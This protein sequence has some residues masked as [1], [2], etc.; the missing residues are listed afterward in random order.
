[1]VGWFNSHVCQIILVFLIKLHRLGCFTHTTLC[2]YTYIMYECKYAVYIICNYILLCIHVS[3]YYIFI[4]CPHCFFGV[5]FETGHLKGAP[6]AHRWNG[7]H[8]GVLGDQILRSKKGRR[9]PLE[10]YPWPHNGPKM[11]LEIIKTVHVCIHTHT[12]W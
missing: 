4:Q 3:V 12:L 1:M 6:V 5:S 7:L 11:S 10:K 8:L 9:R 2:V